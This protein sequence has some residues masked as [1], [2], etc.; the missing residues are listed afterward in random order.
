MQEQD[1]LLGKRIGIIAK[2]AGAANL[3]CHYFKNKK[4]VIV[5]SEKPATKIFSEFEFKISNCLKAVIDFGEVFIVGTGSSNFE[6]QVVFEYL[7][8]RERWIPVFDHWIN[9]EKR[10][11]FEGCSLI[12]NEIIVF[13]KYAYNIAV[14]IFEQ[15]QIIELKNEYFS[16]IKSKVQSRNAFHKIKNFLYFHE[17]YEHIFEGQPYWMTCFENFYQHILSVQPQQFTITFRPHPKSNSSNLKNYLKKFKN[18]RLSENKIH[19]D[20]SNCDAAFGI[21]SAALYL[22]DQVGRQV[23]S[24]NI[25]PSFPTFGPLKKMQLINE[26]NF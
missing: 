4:E 16:F 14:E 6:K 21:R 13:D 7:I 18:V 15:S 25:D 23:F 19:E 11:K 1:F 24:T 17:P 8:N 5:F 9:F 26:L 3:I 10:L 20:I 12:P 22:T 2:D